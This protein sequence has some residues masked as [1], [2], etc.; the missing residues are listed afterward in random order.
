MVR[1][2][3]VALTA[4]TLRTLR[5]HPVFAELNLYPNDIDQLIAGKDKVL[6]MVNALNR[7]YFAGQP[8]VTCFTCHRGSG[9]PDVEPDGLL[10]RRPERQRVEWWGS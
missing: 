6:A 2:H 9:I 1:E 8:R 4:Y 5:E 3:E 7:Q 10:A